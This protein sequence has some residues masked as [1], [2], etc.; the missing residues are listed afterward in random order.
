LL[1]KTIALSLERREGLLTR[2]KVGVVPVPVILLLKVHPLVAVS[3][4][5]LNRPNLLLIKQALQLDL[6][7]LIHP[8]IGHASSVD[9]SV[10]MPTIVQTRLL[11]LLRLR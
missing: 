8:Q 10:T 1:S 3:G 6:L 5:K 7:L 9:R 11:I 4:N 2:D